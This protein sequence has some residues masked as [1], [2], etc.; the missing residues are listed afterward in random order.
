MTRRNLACHILPRSAG[1]QWRR[2]VEHLNRRWSLFNGRKIV[3]IALDDDCDPAADVRRAFDDQSIEFLEFQNDPRLGESLTFVP[4]LEPLQSLRADEFT[5]RCHAKGST[6]ARDES[7]S[8]LWADVMFSTC[9]DCPELIDAALEEH[10][11]CGSMRI[12]ERPSG[13]W[14]Y[15]GSFY[16]LRHDRVFSRN[17][18]NIPWNW[19]GAEDWPGA[20]FSIEETA[21]L[22]LDQ[23]GDVPYDHAYWQLVVLPALRYWEQRVEATGLEVKP[24][25]VPEWFGRMHPAD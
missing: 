3:A 25:G 23:C 9:L 20:N 13:Y 24:Y 14:I 10:A 21:C 16:W 4:S 18:R 12:W 19:M 1:H 2:T 11:L 7:I 8:H 5:F 22:F 6:W 15:A 17:W